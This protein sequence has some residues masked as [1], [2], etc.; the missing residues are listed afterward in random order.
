MLL[1]TAEPLEQPQ[2]RMV[3]ERTCDD[4]SQAPLQN[5]VLLADPRE[6]AAFE[7]ARRRARDPE[8]EF[9]LV[10]C[11]LLVLIAIRGRDRVDRVGG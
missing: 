4:V 9:D 8:V 11:G 10:G 3:V 6:G 7:D 2:R 1:R 5:L